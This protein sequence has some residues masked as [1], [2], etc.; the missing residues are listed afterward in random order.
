M[1]HFDHFD[2]NHEDK[3]ILNQFSKANFLGL[4]LVIL[5]IFI[6]K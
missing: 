3:N 6:T 1:N 5:C 2:S 4:G